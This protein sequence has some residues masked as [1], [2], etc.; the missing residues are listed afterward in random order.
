MLV[1]FKPRAAKTFLALQIVF[2]VCDFAFAYAW[3]A[4][5]FNKIATGIIF[6]EVPLKDIKLLQ[7]LGVEAFYAEFLIALYF[8]SLIVSSLIFYGTIR[9]FLAPLAR[10]DWMK[11]SWA[12]FAF[13]FVLILL[14]LGPF[15]NLPWD[16]ALRLYP[17]SKVIYN[18]MN[19]V[20]AGLLTGIVVGK[21]LP[22][23]L[24][25]LTKRSCYT[26][27]VIDESGRKFVLMKIKAKRC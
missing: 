9:R 27:G 8:I 1:N 2:L 26:L 11:L 20:T 3:T 18:I 21:V 24:M 17:L 22:F 7:S 4:M 6:V 12:S 5:L 25:P 16:I 23:Y 19:S 13:Y 10:K 15:I 14:T